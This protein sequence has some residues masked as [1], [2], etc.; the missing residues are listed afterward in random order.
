LTQYSLLRGQVVF[1]ET[2]VGWTALPE[3]LGHLVRQRTRW[4]T[5]FYRGSLWMLR[6]MPRTRLAY[7]LTV[8]NVARFV[9][10][11]VLLVGVALLATRIEWT[12]LGLDWV[13][14][15]VTYWYFRGLRYLAFRRADMTTREQLLA[16][17]VGPLVSLLYALVLT[18]TSYYAL[19]RL[20][21]G[22]WLTRAVVQVR[23][24]EEVPAG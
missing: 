3:S 14:Y 11:G 8:V 21:S 15:L 1:Q 23:V 2:F 22:S 16:F 19:S 7:W 9:A 17:A 4:Y 10:R 12:R 5:S 18:P 6:Y 20:R 24:G 13:V